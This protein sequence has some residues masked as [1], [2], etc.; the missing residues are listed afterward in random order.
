VVAGEQEKKAGPLAPPLAPGKE[1]WV[2]EN[3]LPLWLVRAYEEGV[4]R[5]EAAAALREQHERHQASKRA[6]CACS[7]RQNGSSLLP[8]SRSGGTH[9]ICAFS[10]TRQHLQQ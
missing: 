5:A 3:C 1:G 8:I 7:H 6:A 4:R 10:P 2:A 9:G